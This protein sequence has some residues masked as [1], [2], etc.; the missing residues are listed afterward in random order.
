M[1]NWNPGAVIVLLWHEE[2]ANFSCFSV[3]II[4]VRVMASLRNPGQEQLR[5]GEKC[6]PWQ[7]KIS[8]WSNGGEEVRGVPFPLA[9]W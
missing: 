3:L 2:G 4:T 6:N 5:Y 1:K 7:C 9:C 8:N